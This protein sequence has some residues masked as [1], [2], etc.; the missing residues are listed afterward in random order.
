MC[1]QSRHFLF[2]GW[3]FYQIQSASN[4]RSLKR[5]RNFRSYSGI[6]YSPP[7]PFLVVTTHVENVLAGSCKNSRDRHTQ[8]SRLCVCRDDPNWR[9]T[10]REKLG[11]FDVIGWSP[12]SER[13]FKRTTFP[14]DSIRH[15]KR[16][17]LLAASSSLLSLLLAQTKVDNSEVKFLHGPHRKNKRRASNGPELGSCAT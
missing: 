9:D 5:E 17:P 16:D 4:F 15:Q 7:L 2:F 13:R 12:G 10:R 6:D 3:N 11:T 8:F 1:P 14:P